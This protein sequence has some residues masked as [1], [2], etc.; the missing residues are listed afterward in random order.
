MGYTTEF[1]GSWRVTP[2]LK[3][4]HAAYLRAFCKT[5][6]VRRNPALTAPRPDALR[7]AAGL[8]LG[9]EAGYFVGAS[10]GNF[11]QEH[12]PDVLDYSTEPKGQPGLWCQWTPNAAGDAIEW[13][14]VE[15]FYNYQ[16]WLI[17][18]MEHFLKPWGYTLNGVVEWQ[19]ERDED[20]GFLLAAGTEVF[21]LEDIVTKQGKV[22]YGGPPLTPAEAVTLDF[23]YSN[24]HVASLTEAGGPRPFDSEEA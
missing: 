22:Q 4:E 24:G 9:E 18:L 1:T 6:R 19:G 20:R 8:P 17:Y 10:L 11:G 16:E 13:D 15:K 7:V 23:C 5:R 14:G 2:P 12:T 21:S 3:P